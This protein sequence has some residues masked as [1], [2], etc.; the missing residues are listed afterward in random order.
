MT[1]EGRPASGAAGEWQ[2][3]GWGTRR[4]ARS[5]LAEPDPARPARAAPPPSLPLI[6]H[7][8]SHAFSPSRPAA[9]LPKTMGGRGALSKMCEMPPIFTRHAAFAFFAAI[10]VG[11]PRL[12]FAS[13]R[14]GH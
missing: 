14:S 7:H 9:G 12:S 3:D 8:N 11:S 13:F 5:A 10:A 4:P 1:K 6:H 2:C